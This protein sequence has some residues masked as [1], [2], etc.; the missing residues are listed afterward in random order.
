MLT[1]LKIRN[2][3]LHS[4]MQQRARLKSLDRFKAAVQKIDSNNDVLELGTNTQTEE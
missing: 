1:F 2:Y 3:C 4:K